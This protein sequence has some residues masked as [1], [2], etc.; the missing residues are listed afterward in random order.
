ML[1]PLRESRCL[2]DGRQRWIR[3]TWDACLHINCHLHL[4]EALA[5]LHQKGPRCCV[6][7]PFPPSYCFISVLYVS[8]M[9]QICIRA[10]STSYRHDC[11]TGIKHNIICISLVSSMY[12]YR[13]RLTVSIHISHVSSKYHTHI[14]H[15]LCKNCAWMVCIMYHYVSR[16]YQAFSKSLFTCIIAYHTCIYSASLGNQCIVQLLE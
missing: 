10:R 8:H 4:V 16:M 3:L 5:K 9:Y 13:A 6:W 7:W 1:Q 11:I 15:V 2:S 14:V 12:L